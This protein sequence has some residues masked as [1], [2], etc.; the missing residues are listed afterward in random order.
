MKEEKKVYVN[1]WVKKVSNFGK[2]LN[3][4][5]TKKTYKSAVDSI[6]YK[7]AKLEVEAAYQVAKEKGGL[8]NE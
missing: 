8:D 5:L 1:F 4:L 7:A 6:E 2:I 3:E